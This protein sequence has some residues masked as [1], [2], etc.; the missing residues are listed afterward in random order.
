MRQTGTCALPQRLCLGTNH[1]HNR[2]SQTAASCTDKSDYMIKS[3]NVAELPGKSC[4]AAGYLLAR[5]YHTPCC[6]TG[7]WS[8][9]FRRS[10]GTG[11]YHIIIN[12]YNLLPQWLSRTDSYCVDVH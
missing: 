10:S 3:C 2:D 11:L 8:M 4:Q 9:G 6:C 1:S 12:D 5:L 7:L